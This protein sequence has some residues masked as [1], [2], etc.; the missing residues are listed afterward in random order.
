M[1]PVDQSMYEIVKDYRDRLVFLEFPP[2]TF[3][4]ILDIGSTIE[5]FIINAI[6]KELESIRKDKGLDS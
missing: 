6:D 5:D 4:R 1:Y 2:G 3:Q